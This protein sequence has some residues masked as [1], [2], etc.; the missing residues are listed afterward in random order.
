M[1]TI[2]V[3]RIYILN[4]IIILIILNYFI[5]NIQ[6]SFDHDE[7]D[8]IFSNAFADPDVIVKKN[9]PDA[10]VFIQSFDYDGMKKYFSNSPEKHDQHWQG[11][12]ATADLHLFTAL[13]LATFPWWLTLSYENVFTKIYLRCNGT[14]L[15]SELQNEDGKAMDRLLQDYN[16][17]L[18]KHREL[19]H[20]M[21]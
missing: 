6:S 11:I 4:L 5:I 2:I 7:F 9:R 15:H 10:H 20:H 3:H 19:Y 18:Q 13:H 1:V 16:I 14:F 12:D 21:Q 17:T 8:A